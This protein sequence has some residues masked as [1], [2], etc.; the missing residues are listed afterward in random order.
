[1]SRYCLVVPCYNEAARLDIEALASWLERRRDLC[2]VFVDDGSTD[3]TGAVLRALEA[4]VGPQAKVLGLARNGGK[5]EAVRAGLLLALASDAA[6]VGYYDADLSTSIAEMDR[7]LDDCTNGE[8]DF[9]M[10]A[11][12]SLLGRRIERNAVRHYLGRVFATGASMALRLRVYDTQCGAKLIR[13][14]AALRAALATPFLSR[15]AFDVELIGRL[16]HPA[17]GVAA[18]DVQRILEE[19]LLEWR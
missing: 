2:L 15:W 7:L 4:R 1:M 19:P 14:N 16:M 13:S 11:R 8:F 18:L 17:P 3:E 6:F 10:A 9:V 5:A 12:V